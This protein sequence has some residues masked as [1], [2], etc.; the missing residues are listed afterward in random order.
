MLKYAV[1][2]LYIY[3]LKK[4]NLFL[5][6]IYNKFG[7]QRG[8]REASYVKNS[9]F[10]L[11]PIYNSM[12]NKVHKDFVTS[13]LHSLL[14]KI[15][16]FDINPRTEVLLHDRYI[17]S[18][19]SWHLTVADKGKIWISEKLDNI[20]TKYVDQ[21]LD[22]PISDVKFQQ[23]QTTLRSSLKSSGDETIMHL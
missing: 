8:A 18:K 10:F 6:P 17:L 13:N 9:N 15:D 2:W 1:V 14:K 11:C 5:C 21:W 16:K 7:A 3:K 12:D 23:C 22:I 20:V 19:I 4:S